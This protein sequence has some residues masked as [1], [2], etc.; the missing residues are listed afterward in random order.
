VTSTLMTDRR[1]TPPHQYTQYSTG[2]TTTESSGGGTPATLSETAHR[3]DEEWSASPQQAAG[4]PAQSVVLAVW[5]VIPSSWAEPN[6]S[7][8]LQVAVSS[9]SAPSP[10]DRIVSLSAAS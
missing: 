9:V 1:D 6:P 7:T 5:C 4:V 3:A 10:S 2:E 8:E